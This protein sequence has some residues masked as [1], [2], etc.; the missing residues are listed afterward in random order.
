[1]TIASSAGIAAGMLT[2]FA[3]FGGFGR[4]RG[5]NNSG[6]PVALIG[7]WSAW[8]CTPSASC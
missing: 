5:N 2:R 4:A 1:M 6:V 7:S 3:Q 8:S